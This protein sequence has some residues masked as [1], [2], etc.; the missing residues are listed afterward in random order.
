ML[1]HY[2]SEALE[3]RADSESSG[4]GASPASVQGWSGSSEDEEMENGGPM[5][6][7]QDVVAGPKGADKGTEKPRRP[8]LRLQPNANR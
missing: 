6:P 7:S 4:D 8:L 3:A 5:P 1:E 2:K